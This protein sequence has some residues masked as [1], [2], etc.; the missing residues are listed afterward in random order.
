MLATFPALVA[1]YPPGLVCPFASIL[2]LARHVGAISSKA[3]ARHLMEEKAP[4]RSAMVSRLPKFG[5]RSSS[6]GASP[7]SNGSTQPT[8]PAQD[9]KTTPSGTRPNGVIRA[10]PFS[11]KWKRDEGMAHSSPTTPTSPG[12]AGEDKAQTQL[13]SLA[14]EVMNGSPA[15]P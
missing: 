9:G 4:I 7:L 10:S 5:G 13:P 1:P 8:T 6:G 2:L 12:D 3:S 11:L 14:K 15:T